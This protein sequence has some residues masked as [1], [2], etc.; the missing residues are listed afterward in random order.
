VHPHRARARAAVLCVAH[1]GRIS[2][3]ATAEP[4]HR[5]AF[6]RCARRRPHPFPSKSLRTA[7]KVQTHALAAAGSAV[8]SPHRE[9]G[10][11]SPPRHTTH[12]GPSQGRCRA[13]PCN[14]SQKAPAAWGTAAVTCRAL[15]CQLCL[16][17]A[18]PSRGAEGVLDS[19]GGCFANQPSARRRRACMSRPASGQIG[20]GE[21]T[22]VR[23][24]GIAVAEVLCP[25]YGDTVPSIVRWHKTKIVDTLTHH[26]GYTCSQARSRTRFR[27]V[28]P[29]PVRPLFLVACKQIAKRG[30]QQPRGPARRGRPLFFLSNRVFY[31]SLRPILIFAN[32]DISITKIYLDTSILEKSIMGRREYCK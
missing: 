11:L 7:Y 5:R 1:R 28:M 32:T 12:Y 6:R 4:P 20:A 19:S 21:G 13:T 16:S 25:G 23:R 8:S 15:W 18:A 10:A 31:Y 29:T 2:S 17:C 9:V 22:S 26:P 3:I 27:I 30:I 14:P 24:G